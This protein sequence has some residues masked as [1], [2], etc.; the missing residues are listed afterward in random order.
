MATT[1]RPARSEAREG[2]STHR[3]GGAKPPTDSDQTLE[4]PELAA[5]G[6]SKLVVVEQTTPRTSRPPRH[7]RSQVSREDPCP[8]GNVDGTVVCDGTFVAFADL[9]WQ[10]AEV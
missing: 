5:C 2:F 8:L 1:V 7:R 4:K 3:R 6:Q 10:D 9:L